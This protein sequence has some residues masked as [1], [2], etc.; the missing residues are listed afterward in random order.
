MVIDDFLDLEM[1]R[2]PDKSVKTERCNMDN[3]AAS[4]VRMFKTPARNK[5]RCLHPHVL[6]AS[7]LNGSCKAI[8]LAF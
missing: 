1:A 7:Q 4:V 6:I 3:L 5:V 2:S 8:A